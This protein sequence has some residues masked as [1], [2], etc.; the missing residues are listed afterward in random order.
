VSQASKK[1]PGRPRAEPRTPPPPEL[2]PLHVTRLSRQLTNRRIAE[3]SGLPVDT[4][5]DFFNGRSPDPRA[6]TV[7]AIARGL[8][9]GFAW[10]G[11]EAIPEMSEDDPAD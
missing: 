11:T 6:S 3:A 8:G 10:I 1:R 9:V 5:A 2:L 7:F 4:V